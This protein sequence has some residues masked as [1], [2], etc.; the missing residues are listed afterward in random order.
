MD[1]SVLKFIIIRDDRLADCADW[2]TVKGP[3]PAFAEPYYYSTTTSP[4]SVN[5]PVKSRNN[6]ENN[7]PVTKPCS[8]FKRRI[9]LENRSKQAIRY[10]FR[11]N[12][13]CKSLKNKI[14]IAFS[15]YSVL[16]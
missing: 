3:S 2:E 7:I 9:P 14:K 4:M 5:K 8:N 10:K 13:D 15:R 11:R 12:A 1:D 6:K 16:Q